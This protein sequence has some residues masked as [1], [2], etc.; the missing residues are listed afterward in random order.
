MFLGPHR[1]FFLEF[2][3]NLSP[4][5]MLLTIALVSSFRLDMRHLDL[6][7][8]GIRNVLPSA[9][10]VAV[11]F[12]AMMANVTQFLERM[13]EQSKDVTQALDEKRKDVGLDAFPGRSLRLFGAHLSASWRY[14]KVGMVRWLVALLVVEIGMVALFIS[15]I[16][17]A[18]S[19]LNAIRAPAYAAQANCSAPHVTPPA[20]PTH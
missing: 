1:A 2:L 7:W 13:T 12:I 5:I 11:F 17:A 20:R 19:A 4:Q 18:T 15:A 16:P 6:S 3:R 8:S 10:I 14:D 9:A